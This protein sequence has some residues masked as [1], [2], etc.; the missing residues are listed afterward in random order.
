MTVCGRREDDDHIILTI[1]TVGTA[2]WIKKREAGS[3]AIVTG[4][5]GMQLCMPVY[6]LRLSVWRVFLPQVCGGE[7]IT[8]GMRNFFH[9]IPLPRWYSTEFGFNGVVLLMQFLFGPDAVKFHFRPVCIRDGRIY[10][11]RPYMTRVSTF[12]FP[13]CLL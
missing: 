11:G 10:A 8:V 9:L 2:A 13:F 1:L 4:A 6:A 12:C 3:G 7:A 5:A